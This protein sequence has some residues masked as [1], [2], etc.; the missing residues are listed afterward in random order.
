M[1]V[2]V[3]LKN[4]LNSLSTIPLYTQLTSQIKAM[5]QSGDIAVGELLP[6]ELELCEKLSIS[7]S[8]VRQAL[9]NLETEGF[10]VR[11]RGKGTYASKPKVK[12]KLSKLCSFTK[13]MN[14]LGVD[15][16]SDIME[17]EIVN[18]EDVAELYG[19]HGDVFKVVRLRETDGLP[20]MIDTVYVPAK[21]APE[22]TKEALKGRSL[23]DVVEEMT[24][25]AP[26][27]AVETYEVVKLDKQQTEI[28]KTQNQTA[29]LVKRTTKLVS[30]EL[31]EIATMLIRGDRCRLEATLESDTVAFLRTLQ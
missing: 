16:A 25:C 24:G 5:I 4:K 22:L 2:E 21:I 14:E 10:V 11:R 17:F 1:G 7:R 26:H 18:S 31:F 15:C 13:H 8:T 29:F 3:L 27:S 28:L 6:S 9:S 23:Y 12:R 19:Y 20:F 30:G